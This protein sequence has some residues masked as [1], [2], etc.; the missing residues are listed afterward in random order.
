MGMPMDRDQS[1]FRR[2]IQ[3]LRGISV[4]V[5][6]LYH[7]GLQLPGGFVGVDM[8]F[9]ISGFVVSRLIFAEVQ[10]TGTFSFSNFFSRR[11]RRLIPILTLVNVLT[12]LGV[13]LFLSPFGERQQASATA[14][15]SAF[16]SANINLLQDNSYINLIDNPF[17]HLWSLAVEEQFY[18]FFPI[19]VVLCL[20]ISRRSHRSF[21]ALSVSALSVLAVCSFMLAMYSTRSA[22]GESWNQ[23]GFFGLPTRIWEFVTGI[24][25]MV[26]LG[27]WRIEANPRITLA[28]RCGVIGIAWALIC[29]KESN[30]FP[31]ITAL[32]PVV[33]TALLLVCSVQG[34]LL[35][36]ILSAPVLVRIGDASYGWYLWHWP[37]IVFTQRVW[38]GQ[39]I[40]TCMASIFALVLSFVSL[41]L[42][43]NPIRSREVLA[44]RRTLALLVSCSLIVL[45]TARIVSFDADRTTSLVLAGSEDK[46][47][48]NRWGQGLALR[49]TFLSSVERCHSTEVPFIVDTICSNGITIAQPTAF[50]IGDSHADSAS[51]GVLEAGKQ[52][53]VKTFGWYMP[54]CP[55]FSGYFVN[56]SDICDSAKAFSMSALSHYNVETVIIVDSYV[57]YLTGEQPADE[58]DRE[59]RN[60]KISSF[61][62]DKVRA[63]VLALSPLVDE[64]GTTSQHV[65]VMLEVPFAIMPG[66]TGLG[67][68]PAHELLRRAINNEITDRFE[69]NSDVTVFDP[70]PFL[71]E[72]KNPCDPASNESSLYWH[73]THLNK[74]GSLKLVEGWKV[75]FSSLL[76]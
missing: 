42:I 3:G 33:S 64:V 37:M 68:C 25:A 28:G 20:L 75:V 72:G 54:G 60:G 32:I 49:D 22:A 35:H 26:F 65:V 45:V 40:A 39:F 73:K 21:I 74:S 13:H 1:Y 58:V 4:L 53:G 46:A 62:S 31:Q 48:A 50:L 41:R 19:L 36:K 71:L 69:N 56:D 16:F 38:P 34:S 8:F 51:N 9:V 7:A 52:L 43:E 23:F 57:T 67:E 2:D 17:R 70:E 30:Q 55:L 63:I 27:R 6:V 29:L 5:V 47:A 12:L 44:G 18:L 59:L 61:W 66:T 24:L 11:I 14:S 15:A 76:K 10:S